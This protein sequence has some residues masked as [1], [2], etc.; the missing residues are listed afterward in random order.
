[1]WMYPPDQPTPEP[2][3]YDPDGSKG[4][5]VF[6]GILPPVIP[7]ASDV[8]YEYTSPEDN[9]D[10]FGRNTKKE[11]ALISKLLRSLPR[12]SAHL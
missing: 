8:V 6:F 3:T 12:I 2:G 10:L 1:M 4:E 7:P 11:T 9:Q 5:S